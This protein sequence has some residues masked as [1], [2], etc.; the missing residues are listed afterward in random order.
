MP[1][2]TVTPTTSSTTNST[3][4]SYLMHGADI[5]YGTRPSCMIPTD[6]AHRA[7]SCSV[8][9]GTDSAYRAPRLPRR[10]HRRPGT[11]AAIAYAYSIARPRT[12]LTC[13]GTTRGRLRGSWGSH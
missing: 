9:C 1:Y 2:T 8:M 13:G 7:T 6:R 10:R 11:N 3:A 5:A 4:E 12:D